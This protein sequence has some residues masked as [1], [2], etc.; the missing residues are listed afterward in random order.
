MKEKILFVDD[1]VHIL[2]SFRV[3]LRKDYDV[4]IALGPEEGLAKVRESGPFA[5]VVSDLKMPGMDGIDFLIQVKEKTPNTVRVM[6]T[7][8][9]DF[10]KAMDAVNRGHIFR[11][12]QKPCPMDILK[13]ALEDGLRQYRLI[14]AERDLLQKTLKGAIELVNEI[15]A[16]VNPEAFGR[17]QRILRYI[18]Y[19]VQQKDLKDGW[20]H[21]MAAMLSQV[22]C[23]TLSEATLKKI[24]EGQELTREETQLYEMHPLIGSSLLARIPRLEE[25]ARIVS[26]QEKG[27]DGSGVPHDPVQGEDIP[28]GARMLKLVLDYDA[29]LARL[30]NS[31]KAFLFIESQG[32]RY[33]PEL[34]YILE[35]YLGVEA[36][37]Q[38]REVTLDGLRSGMILNADVLSTDGVLMARKG[39]EVSGL[40]RSRLEAFAKMERIEPTFKVLV[41]IAPPQ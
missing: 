15:V 6:L 35:G 34:L 36:R 5:V 12:L 28:L 14:L 9:G 20:R 40:L 23:L 33:D 19:M 22:G 18:R 39:L 10:D 8:H 1:E 31:G 37:Y 4:D 7:G 29:A 17:S 21:E 25:V 11:F 24:Q 2:D 13:G 16:L 32:E 41:P 38:L 30:G 27:F 26:Y 3:G